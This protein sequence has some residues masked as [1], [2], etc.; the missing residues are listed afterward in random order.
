MRQVR[1][2]LACQAGRGQA[3]G[4]DA[5]A[6]SRPDGP[7]QDH[8]RRDD[9]GD[10]TDSQLDSP[11]GQQDRVAGANVGGPAG[12]GH[13]GAGPVAADHLDQLHA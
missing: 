1:P 9:I 8:L 2:V 10:D 6:L 12:V 11:V 13:P 7:A 3:V 5:D 4:R